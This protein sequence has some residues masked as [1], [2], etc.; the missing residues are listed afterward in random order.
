[1][2]PKTFV[3]Y[4]KD[5]YIETESGNKISRDAVVC[6]SQY[7]VLGGKC[8]IESKAILRGDL[9]R[10]AGGGAVSIAMG[11]YCVQRHDAIIRPPYKVYKDLFS[12]YPVR[13]GDYV[14]IGE[15][16]IVEAA[17]IGSYVIIG[18]N[19]TIVINM[20]NSQ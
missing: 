8:I 19:C 6:G 9:R 13:M 10:S 17:S 11:K 20:S 3:R 12:Y 18:S 16:S 5:G 15:Q 14:Y 4:D 2:I 7:I 1:M